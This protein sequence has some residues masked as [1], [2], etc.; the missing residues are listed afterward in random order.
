[1]SIWRTG[2]IRASKEAMRII[3]K[4]NSRRTEPILGCGIVRMLK[5][6]LPFIIVY[7][8]AYSQVSDSCIIDIN[9]M[10]VEVLGEL[11]DGNLIIKFKDLQLD[12]KFPASLLVKF[13]D[14]AQISGKLLVT[15]L[16]SPFKVYKSVAVECVNPIAVF[17]AEM[18]TNEEKV[19]S[20]DRE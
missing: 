2:Q 6:D 14:I 17:S 16:S 4:I 15:P 18:D 13:A 8:S 19:P 12:G 5:G 1:M 3:D 20:A 9:L 10:E 7:D 11:A